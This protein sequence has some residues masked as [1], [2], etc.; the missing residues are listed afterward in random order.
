[1]FIAKQGTDESGYK[2]FGPFRTRE[3]ALDGADEKTTIHSLSL[4]RSSWSSDQ[5]SNLY[6]KV[7]QLSP[8]EQAKAEAVVIVS[9]V[10]V[11]PQYL[12]DDS[13][14]LHFRWTTNP[15]RALKVSIEKADSLIDLF[16][17]RHYHT[18]GV[19]E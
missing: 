3:E 14:A 6:E 2:Y 10:G 1:M 17:R 11:K 5:W 8:E 16:G 9:R 15:K 18:V 12:S 7:R 19:K 4:C 13:D